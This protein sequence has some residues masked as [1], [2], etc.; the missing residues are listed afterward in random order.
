M[1]SVYA[2]EIPVNFRI[3]LNQGQPEPLGYIFTRFKNVHVMHDNYM[4]CCGKINK[5]NVF[6]YKTQTRPKAKITETMIVTPAVVMARREYI[7]TI[8]EDRATPALPKRSL[9]TSASD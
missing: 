7:N 2:I 9:G 1:K 5:H 6:C 8:M 4:I 3:K